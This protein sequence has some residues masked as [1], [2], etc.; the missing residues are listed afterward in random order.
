ME[1]E[2]ARTIADA[3]VKKLEP[4]CEK[5]AVAGSIRRRRPFVNDIDLVVIP[6]DPWNLH[7]EI[8]GLCRPYPAKMG[9]TKIMRIPVAGIDIDI[10][11]A[12]EKTWAT[13]LLI[14]TG[15]TAHNIKLCSIAKKRGW[16]LAANGDG[17]FNETGSRLAG[18]TEQSIFAML[19]EKYRQPE[20]RE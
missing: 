20:E 17:L 8:L 3:V 6:K 1:L 11:F 16:H 13:L 9:G 4:Y 7:Q 18:E 2:R 14:R 5:I 10:Y 19:G 12:D 15:S